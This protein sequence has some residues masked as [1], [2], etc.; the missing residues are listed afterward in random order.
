M[1]QGNIWK[2]PQVRTVVEKIITKVDASMLRRRCSGASVIT[3]E[4][5]D[6]LF[7]MEK[8]RIKHNEYLFSALEQ[9]GTKSYFELL[10]ILNTGLPDG[11]DSLS[12]ELRAAGASF[13]ESMKNSQSNS[14]VPRKN[15]VSYRY[16]LNYD[17]CVLCNMYIMLYGVLFQVPAPSLV[18]SPHLHN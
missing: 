14:T 3:L 7:S 5:K 2:Y 8:N 11:Q 10:K 16:L 15:D 1:S 17:V 6:T 9:S 18:P 4:C 13:F 12:D